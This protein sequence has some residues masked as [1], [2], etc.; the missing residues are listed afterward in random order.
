MEINTYTKLKFR[1]CLSNLKLKMVLAWPICV[2]TAAFL[3][4][5]SVWFLKVTTSQTFSWLSISCSSRS[6]W[7]F[8]LASTYIYRERK[9]WIIYSHAISRIA[10]EN[11]IYQHKYFLSLQFVACVNIFDNIYLQLNW[12]YFA[13]TVTGANCTID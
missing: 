7:I 2:A 9:V 4:V 5:L 13:N 6:S 3:S 1:I 8:L 11:W 12:V 10:F